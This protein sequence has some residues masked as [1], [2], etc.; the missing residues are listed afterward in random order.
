MAEGSGVGIRFQAGTIPFLPKVLKLAEQFQD[1]GIAM[2]ESSFGPKVTWQGDVP[3]PVR[4]VLWES[5]SSG[6]LLVALAPGRVDEYCRRMADAGE[7]GWSVGEVIA[8]TPGTIT[9]VA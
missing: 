8:G 4:N 6:G 2:N 3:V 9:V 5:Q 1:P 7:Q